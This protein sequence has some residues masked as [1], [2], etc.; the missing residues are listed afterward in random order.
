MK[1]NL[2]ISTSKNKIRGNVWYEIGSQKIVIERKIV[3]QGR[4]FDCLGNMI[5]EYKKDMEYK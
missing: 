4:E 3:E 2:K 5:S 1:Y